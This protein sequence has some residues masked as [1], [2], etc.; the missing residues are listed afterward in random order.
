[1]K[2]QFAI[3]LEQIKSTMKTKERQTFLFD[4][5]CLVRDMR[6]KKFTQWAANCTNLLWTHEELR[7]NCV[8]KSNKSTRG[9]LDAEKV[10]LLHGNNNKILYLF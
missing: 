2:E 7:E 8:Y 5:K 4:G 9:A 6:G 10:K 3:E 1:M